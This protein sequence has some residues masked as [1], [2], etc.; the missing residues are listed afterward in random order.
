[1][2]QASSSVP[3]FAVRG[4][5]SGV[6]F[7]AFFGTLWASI[8]IGGL[9]GWGGLWLP[10]I[11]VGIGVGL[12]LAGFS[13][14]RSS[15]RLPDAVAETDERRGKQTGR[16][17]VIIFAA[18]GL[19]IGIASIICNA[20]GRFDLFFPIM[21]AIV[22]VHFF[23]LAA[24]FEVKPY[25]LVGALLCLLAGVTLLVVPASASLGGRQITAQS[26]VLGLGAACILWSVGVALW[27]LGKRLLA[28]A[29]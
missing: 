18:E 2:T 5:A 14:I 20:I 10:V 29:P 21:A 4:V 16:W 27:L 19:L 15:R 25:Y 13:L 28:S 22:G 3:G 9:Q 6:L 7:M 8:G 26:V 1:M 23:P 24:L 11:A 17:F 12:L